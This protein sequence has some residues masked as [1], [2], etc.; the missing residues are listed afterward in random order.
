M[1]TPSRFR[2]FAVVVLFLVIVPTAT[3][4]YSGGSGTVQDPYRIGTP[5]DLIALGETP[6]DYDK[7]FVLTA[8]IDLDPNLP[9]RKAFDRSVIAPDTDP[10]DHTSGGGPLFTGPSFTG[11]LEGNS[12]KISHLTVRA[13]AYGGLFGHLASRAEVRDLALV[14]ALIVC[15][16]GGALAASSTGTITRCYSTGAVVSGSR[17]GGLVGQNDG[18]VA[19]CYSVATVDGVVYLGGLVGYNDLAGIV[20]QCYSAGAV[21]V[22]DEPTHVGGLVGYNLGIVVNCYSTATVSG[23]SQIASEG[24]PENVGVGGLV[25]STEFG[26]VSC[27]YSTG[28]V[29]GRDTLVGLVGTVVRRLDTVTRSFFDVQASGGWWPSD[30]SGT[31]GLTTREMQDIRT[32]QNAGWDF[33]NETANGT[34][35]IWQ[36]PPG[37]GY[38]ILAALGGYTPPR[39]RGMGRPED[40]YL[41]S[42]ATEIGAMVHYGPCAHYRLVASIDLSGIRWPTS[43]IPWFGGTFDGQGHT[44]SNLRIERGCYLGLFGRVASAADVRDLGV[45][46]VAIGD[47]ECVGAR[48]GGLV[49]ANM[50]S[51]SGCYA[52]GRVSS[53]DRWSVFIGGLVGENAGAL[54]QC[55]GTVAVRGDE[56]V[57]GLAGCNSYG[58]GVTDCHSTGAVKGHDFVGGLLGDNGGPVLRCFSGGVITGNNNV[59]GLAGRNWGSLTRCYTDSTV[60][61]TGNDNV[62][63]LVGYNLGPVTQC[64]SSPTI[65]ASSN[66]GGLVGYN[67]ASITQCYVLPGVLLGTEGVGGLTGINEGT[68]AD[69]YVGYAGPYL[70]RYRVQGEF[71]VGGLVG[72]N[73]NPPESRARISNCYAAAE[74]VGT[75]LVGGLLGQNAYGDVT[76]CF[77]D[78][79]TSRQRGSA[80]GTGKT[81]SQMKT[82]RTYSLAGWDFL[83][84]WSMP[85][86]P[87][88]AGDYPHL[89]WEAYH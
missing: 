9:G 6:G 23:Y 27:C 22:G 44:I 30:Y 78:I 8:D 2:A 86:V 89:Q 77:W 63:G 81:T 34:S 56:Y 20:S 50:G 10:G 41:I 21:G 4:K 31:P 75:Q 28:R 69:S 88:S 43:V 82:I 74:V 72:I 87:G 49:G 32:Y 26:Y 73:R 36:M 66:V 85:S 12:H 13:Q 80:G 52:T 60:D 53:T 14:D 65:S 46:D 25:G 17:A 70:V 54:A 7:H 68:I 62:G 19:Q 11:V 45:V 1:I 67:R 40:P 51:I 57:G 35:Q 38:P 61:I 84:I 3:A 29:L 5:A 37:G 48:V 64:N 16:P 76:G 15:S 79:E 24:S 59:G 55:S 42:D 71:S 33:V 58:I 39:L 83:S 18:A 47:P